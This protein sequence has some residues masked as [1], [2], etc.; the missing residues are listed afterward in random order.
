MSQQTTLGPADNL[1]GRYPVNGL[2]CLESASPWIRKVVEL[3]SAAH[4]QT[5]AGTH[6]CTNT[7][8]LR[9]K[10]TRTYQL[11]LESN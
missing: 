7:R 11:Q 1:T 4:T 2:S 3:A 8:A 10:H 9:L 5:H 6:T